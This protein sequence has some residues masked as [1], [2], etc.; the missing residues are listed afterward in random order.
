MRL[1][2]MFTI[3]FMSIFGGIS[4]LLRTVT[5]LAYVKNNEVAIKVRF[6]SAQR[7]RTAPYFMWVPGKYIPWRL[8]WYPRKL[9]CQGDWIVGYHGLHGG[10]PF[11]DHWPKICISEDP[12]KTGSI[13]CVLKDQMAYSIVGSIRWK[14][15]GD[16]MLKNHDPEDVFKAHFVT[17]NLTVA[18]KNAAEQCILESLSQIEYLE[19]TNNPQSVAEGVIGGLQGIVGVWGIEIIDVGIVAIE[20]TH[21]T[22]ML[23]QLP[24]RVKILGDSGLDSLKGKENLIAALTGSLTAIAAT[25]TSHEQLSADD[26][27]DTHPDVRTSRLGVLHGLPKEA[28]K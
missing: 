26:E 6:S 23:T 14:I 9:R 25:S 18:I 15:F 21:Q 5:G 3:L 24:T 13:P 4:S 20:A 19:L 17:R 22:E 1:P 12:E 2:A 11:I 16:M 7:E 10:I 28:P 27:V 8:K